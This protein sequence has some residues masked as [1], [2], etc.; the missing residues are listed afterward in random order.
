MFE[1]EL[2]INSVPAALAVRAV[3]DLSRVTREFMECRRRNRN[4]RRDTLAEDVRCQ[5]ALFHAGKDAMVKFQP[6]PPGHIFP[7]R[8]LVE[9]A[10]FVIIQ[11]IPWNSVARAPRIIGDVDQWLGFHSVD[12]ADAVTFFPYHSQTTRD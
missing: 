5:F 4:R 6:L 7:Q 10:A 11:A 3:A 9:S 8:D 1:S 12:C 2:R